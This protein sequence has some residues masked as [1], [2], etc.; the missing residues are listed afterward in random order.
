VRIIL[1]S[2]SPRREALLTQTGL[3]FR[4]EPSGV[5][6]EAAGRFGNPASFVEQAALA[7]AEEVASR[8]GDGLVLGA[9]TVVVIGGEALGKPATPADA[10]KMLALLSNATHEVYTGLALVLV[11]SGSIVRRRVDHEMTR[12]TFRALTPEDI[13]GY[14]A[15]GEP[16]DKAGGYGIQGR[17]AALVERIEGCYFNV[18][19]LPLARLV[20]MLREFGVSVWEAGR[21]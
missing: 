20:E 9:D 12:V 13:E 8:V 5:S 4:V 6:E 3:P 17:G 16:M 11:S 2:A 1:A 7:K 19:G 18:V 21:V 10:R 14:M 15:T